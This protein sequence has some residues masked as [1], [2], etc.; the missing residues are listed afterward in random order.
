MIG[1]RR[2]RLVIL[3]APPPERLADFVGCL[4]HATRH[5]K[6]TEG[7]HDNAPRAVWMSKKTHRHRGSL[8]G[9]PG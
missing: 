1:A 6:R 5:E 9:L 2:L 7:R 3:D 4:H 8:S